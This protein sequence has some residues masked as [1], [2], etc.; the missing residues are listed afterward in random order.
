MGQRRSTPRHLTGTAAATAALLVTAGLASAPAS[1]AAAPDRLPD[2]R[3]VKSLERELDLDVAR[4][5]SSGSQAFLLKLRTEPTQRAYA[6]NLRDGKAAARAAAREQLDTV[7]ASQDRVTAALPRGSKVLYK[8][9][10]VLTGV[11]VRTDASNLRSLER[12]P[13]VTAVYPISLKERTNSYAVPLIGG[14]TAWQ[15]FGNRGANT[16]IAIIDTGLDYTHANFGGPG[17]VGAYNAEHAAEDEPANPAYFPSD[18]IIGGYD[19]AGDAYDPGASEG[20]PALTPQPDPNPLDCDGHGSHVGGTAAGLGVN[21]NGSTYAGP[22]DETTPFDSLKIGPGVAPAAKLYAL[23]VF[24][25]EGSTD[26]SGAAME[27]A[28]DPNGDGVTS[29][30][31]DVINMSLGSDFGSPFDGDSILV[32]E[33][34]EL[35][36]SMV[37]AS[38]NGGDLFDI[39]GAPG[40]AVRSIAV[41][42][43]VDE[44]TQ[45]TALEITAPAAVVGEYGSDRSIAYDWANDPDLAGVVARV[46]DPTN[47][48]GC[49]PLNQADAAA[50]NGKIAWVEWTNFNGTFPCGSVARAGN[51]AAAGAIGF[52]FATDTDAPAA[53]INGSETI[54]GVLI[55]GSAA[56]TL[57]P[58][59]GNGVT[60]GGT[61][62]A[63]FPQFAAGDNDLVN[64]SS[65]RGVRVEGGVKPDVSAIGTTVFSTGVGTG[66]EGSSFSGTSM[67]A[68]MVAGLS[69]LVV[70]EHPDWTPEEVKADIMNTAGQDLFT[71]PDHTGDKYAPNRVGAGRVS[72]VPALENE[73]LAYVTDDPGAVSASFG[74][75]EVTEQTTLTKTIK[76]ANK[77][78]SSAT[79]DVSYEAITEIPGVE[80]AVAPTSVT[81]PGGAS[82][83]V[84]LTLEIDPAQLTKRIDP[85][86]DLLQEDLPRE[87][88][89]DASGRV[90]FASTGSRPDLRVPVYSA[91]RPASEM[92][93]PAT[94]TLPAG[95]TQV[96]AL[97]L[98]GTGVNQGT[99]SES[100]LSIASVFELQGQSGLAPTCTDVVTT[101]CVHNEQERMA[102][103]KYVGST[104]EFF[105]SN[106]INDGLAYFAIA[107]HGPWRTAASE[108]SFSILMNTDN[109]AEPDFET[110]NTRFT[111]SD[112][113][114]SATF[115]LATGEN[116]DVQAINDSWLFDSG[117]NPVDKLDTALFDSDV[118]VLPVWLKA[119]GLTAGNADIEYSV[120]AFS[121]QSNG[122]PVDVIDGLTLDA[123][124]PGIETGS[125]DG[126]LY[127]DAAGQQIPV[128]RNLADY[129]ASGGEGL[130][131][132]HYHNGVG[133]KAKVV[134]VSSQSVPTNVT[135]GLA[136]TP[137]VA[138]QQVTATVTVANT[139]SVV[140]TGEVTLRSAGDAVLGTANLGP[141][142]TA[143]ITYIPNAAGTFALHAEYVGNSTYLPGESAP[144]NLTV[145]AP[146]SAITLGL[147]PTSVKAGGLVTATVVV[148][149]TAG[150]VPTGVVTVRTSTGTT[151]GSGVL[152]GTGQAVVTFRPKPAGT[153]S[154]LADY[155]GNATYAPGTS[156][157][158]AL[159]VAKNKASVLLRT[160]RQVGAGVK[161]FA[162][163]KVQ[164]LNGIVPTGKVLLK[165]GKK[166]IGSA[167]LTAGK[168][169]VAFKFANA[170]TVKLRAKYVGDGNYTRGRSV[171]KSVRIV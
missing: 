16:T 125:G 80:Y 55:T 159:T 7:E 150:P 98:S 30:H 8:T 96:G 115:D 134:P 143:Q 133:Q 144:Q 138:G 68:P 46:T 161:G 67:A 171:I 131:V 70:S 75:L 63:A 53:G 116:V 39:G 82:T 61:T 38:G 105:G 106:K 168:A 129:Q 136:P 122:E 44:Y 3:V 154:V 95:A 90:L 51:L 66:S 18:K 97:P 21:A 60:V 137:V 101:E 114:V 100:V 166:T 83:T 15:T 164:T 12:I 54:P 33:L 103:L 87:F 27:W 47:L 69:A 65:S 132:V 45:L 41:A 93:H 25:C 64:N 130:L 113:L 56:D 92:T 151:L 40:N 117:G 89:A 158:V 62:A 48:E 153:Y 78:G 165:K 156:N 104:S 5:G 86:M 20:S 152:D 149:D 157:A 9:H 58:Q 170:G 81:V 23:R 6:R 11:A 91:P 32:N 147:V 139:E 124:H 146:L 28:A 35:G 94:L 127:V 108:N 14:D 167:M 121:N 160:P 140:P 109:D 24:G 120:T 77:S 107:T 57:R 50:V 71:D 43:S 13:G 76:V 123:T 29:D 155:A 135:L 118:M 112:T 19:F 99:G 31:V 42:N 72:A 34:S 52:I 22:Y 169:R 85:T 4:P 163:I 74:P 141:A 79:Y 59:L 84:T 37:L 110:F 26:L 119:L 10:S 88:L 102:D 49:N 111:D 142:G 1:S 126:I 36:I 128:T 2:G 73:V 162:T 148:D 145:T 17:T